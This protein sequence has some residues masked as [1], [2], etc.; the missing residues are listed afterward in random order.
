MVGQGLP[1][2]GLSEETQELITPLLVLREW[3][4]HA[5]IF[6][7]S[8]ACQGLHVM[9]SGLVKLYRASRTGREQIVDVVAEPRALSVTPL[10]DGD[11]YPAS[12]TALARTRTV[13]LPRSDFDHLF[14]TRPDF[15]VSMARE[16]ARRV[17]AT[18]AITENISLKQV[19]ARLASRIIENA[20]LCGAWEAPGTFR[21]TLNQEELA[22]L[23]NT[24]RESVARAYS[25]LRRQGLIEQRGSRVRILQPE[26]LLQLAQT[27]P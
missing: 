8:D 1:I 10:F 20:R 5:M 19:P 15:A 16:L 27:S 2:D 9:I 6:R 11:N 23:L 26:T 3:P 21:M 24:S 25:E 18:T 22:R 17:R 7:E 12:A 13:F 14:R 4:A